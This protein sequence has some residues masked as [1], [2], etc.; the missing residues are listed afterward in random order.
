M[1]TPT[2]N[3]TAAADTPAS[4]S[5]VGR[6]GITRPIPAASRLAVINTV[7]NEAR[8][9]G[10]DGT[11]ST[12]KLSVIKCKCDSK[13]SATRPCGSLTWRETCAQRHRYRWLHYE[14]TCC[15]PGCETT[16][17]LLALSNEERIAGI[18]RG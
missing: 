17:A 4:A 2:L 3:G 7:A 9:D 13:T 8:R 6:I 10:V 1:S 14:S 16:R 18:S 5:N 15:S 12:I 11:L